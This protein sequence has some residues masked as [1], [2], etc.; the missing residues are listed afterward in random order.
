MS[1]D[2]INLT[3]QPINLVKLKR[4]IKEIVLKL[5]LKSEISI[6]LVGKQRMRSLN[7]KYRQIDKS[8]DVLSFKE[9]NFNAKMKIGEIFINLDDCQKISN[10]QFFF[11]KSINNYDILLFLIIHGLL[12]LTGLNDNT[13]RKRQAMIKKGINI[14]NELK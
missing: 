9:I 2:I 1:V 11:S 7:K 6:V 3:K 5:K 4:T 12:H 13:E 14:L 8:T 10:Y